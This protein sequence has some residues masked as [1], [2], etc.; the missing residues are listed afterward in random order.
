MYMKKIL[1]FLFLTFFVN[2]FPAFGQA[3]SW[4]NIQD[5]STARGKHWLKVGAKIFS[6]TTMFLPGSVAG[7][8]SI[9]VSC[10]LASTGG[11]H[12]VISLNLFAGNGITIDTGGCS[13]TI[14]NNGVVNL[15]AG[16]NIA[17]G[18]NGSTDTIIN[19]DTI[20]RSVSLHNLYGG[21]VSGVNGAGNNNNTAYGENTL[22]NITL[23]AV[24]NETAIGY[25]ALHNDASG[26]GNVAIGEQAFLH[27][28]SGS[29]NAAVGAGAGS[30]ITT[31]IDE[32]AIGS[33]ALSS[34]TT[35]NR[36]TSVGQA[37]LA[38]VNGSAD[39]TA[40]GNSAGSGIVGGIDNTFLGSQASA[41]S[42]VSNSLAIGFGATVTGTNSGQIGNTTFDS[43]QTH[44]IIQ[45]LGG[46]NLKGTTAPLETNYNAGLIGQF[47]E[48]Q[49]A[50]ATPIW[51]SLIT[52][53][54]SV[55]ASSPLISSG[56]SAPN[57]RVD[58]TANLTVGMVNAKYTGSSYKIG[59]IRFM[60]DT[61]TSNVWIGQGAGAA[62]TTSI[63]NVAVGDSAL[64]FQTTG[65]AGG[66]VNTAIGYA[67]LMVNTTGYQCTAVG[68]NAGGSNTTG[69]NN[70]Y[71]GTSAD[72][73]TTAT[74]S[75]NTFVGFA[76]T[77]NTNTNQQTALGSG[78]TSNGA[79]SMALGFNALAAGANN[80]Q[81]GN[82]SVVMVTT[83]GGFTEGGEMV[84]K[85]V[86]KAGNYAFDAVGT[87]Y[88]VI[89]SANGAT[90]TLPATATLGRHCEI[91]FANTTAANTMT[92]SG[93]GNNING[94]AN[95]TLNAAIAP[96]TAQNSITVVGD[97]TNWWI[98]GSN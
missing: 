61:G 31:A 8:D 81:L 96:F 4:V 10:P 18:V 66:G 87:D 9:T 29:A 33:G 58:T 97:G 73:S 86:T 24:F 28:T 98:V 30:A 43:L 40:V 76:A 2:T 38:S 41:G 85:S 19:T 49:G 55:T 7:I 17:I 71:I 36:N 60:S 68:A 6:D 63:Q 23:G 80:I 12:P 90:V 3:R 77:A 14:K 65:G 48:S 13:D 88:C 91:I 51:D 15:V 47:L 89:E 92:V 5:T 32:V 78:A 70:T 39:N 52:G 79:N 93:N 83:S 62:N 16:K 72:N 22:D 11:T 20:I 50:G 82:A 67:A 46:I 44:A 37:S 75:D 57:I 56:G 94:V 1:V 27:L 25:Q 35:G 54:G 95:V 74:G 21:K 45:P 53:V 59:G 26:S 34:N 69:H 84:L 64:R 42:D